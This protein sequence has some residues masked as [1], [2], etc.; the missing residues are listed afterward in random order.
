MERM[1]GTFNQKVPVILFD[2][3][4]SWGKTTPLLDKYWSLGGFIIL[5]DSVELHCPCLGVK[6]NCSL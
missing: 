5:C 6:R 1:V 3:N 4:W 2:N